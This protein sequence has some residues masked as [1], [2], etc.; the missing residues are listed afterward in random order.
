MFRFCQIEAIYKKHRA[1]IP[2]IEKKL[3]EVLKSTEY[4][5]VVPTSTSA[6][7]KNPKQVRAMRLLAI[8]YY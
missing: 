6:I 1:L 5:K 3:R 8:S 4:G 2:K 7:N